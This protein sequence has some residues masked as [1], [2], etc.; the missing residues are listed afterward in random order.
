M[1]RFLILISVAALATA[2]AAFMAQAQAAD[3]YTVTAKV[4]DT[5][6]MQGEKFKMTGK[7]SPGAGGKTVKLQYLYVTDG[8]D[9]WATVKTTTLKSDSTYSFTVLPSTEGY[10][11]WRVYKAAGSGHAAGASKPILVRPYSWVPLANE[12]DSALGVEVDTTS[13]DPEVSGLGRY[14]QIYVAGNAY[15]KYWET[16]EFAEGKTSWAFDGYCKAVVATFGLDDDSA[17]EARGHIKLYQ[18]NGNGTKMVYD[19]GVTTST[20]DRIKVGVSSS[21]D[22]FTIK[23]TRNYDTVST[24]LVAANPKALCSFQHVA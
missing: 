4:S 21:T 12:E 6:I 19:K 9:S 24:R 7:V 2:P 10:D 17:D 16:N 13:G 8:P 18:H 22:L 5:S 11:K 15:T 20:H 3:K 14:G 1:R 23:G